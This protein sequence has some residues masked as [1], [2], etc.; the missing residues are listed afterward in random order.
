MKKIFLSA[1]AVFLSCVIGFIA[2]LVIFG[3]SHNVHYSPV[4][5]GGGKAYI[6]RGDYTS[7]QCWTVLNEFPN[8]TINSAGVKTIIGRS[9]SDRITINIE[10]PNKKTIHAEAAYNGE[11]LTLEFRPT[12]ITFDISEIKFGITSWLEDIF[13]GNSDII[14]TVGFPETIYEVINIQQGSGTM[15]INDLYSR[16]YDV[17]IG[18][19]K[20]EFNRP[21]S[22]DFKSEVFELDLGSGTAV[23]SGMESKSFDI[24]I[25]SG[26]FTL[27][28]LSGTGEID[29]G[30]GKGS[31]CFVDREETENGRNMHK[32]DIGSGNLTLYYPE[33]GGVVLYSDIG[34]GKIDID[35]FD[36]KKTINS[37][38]CDELNQ[39]V[40]GN[41][42]VDL[43]V[44]M[45]S[46][47][48]TIKDSSSY[49]APEITSEFKVYPS[50]DNGIASGYQDVTIVSGTDS[51]I[52][53]IIDDGELAETGIL[54]E[55]GEFPGL[56]IAQVDPAA[57]VSAAGTISGDISQEAA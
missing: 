11:E 12:N 16:W 57:E 53:V 1:F 56:E 51:E 46:G 17:D 36:Y 44:D 31:I 15:Q 43:K 45:G 6:F 42:A 41:G 34:S 4:Y 50:K 54:S 39:F 26:N 29:M 32:I 9:E 10:N 55:G 3:R 23:F 27:D 13:T 5:E 48:V 33:N 37:S 24:D 21:A 28:R 19:G 35:G 18:S 30:S 52:T 38:N 14:V 22:G 2:S 25:G 7:G 20:C 8:V 47:M 49:T 40:T